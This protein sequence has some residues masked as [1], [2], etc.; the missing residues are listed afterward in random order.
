[1]NINATCQMTE[2]EYERERAELDTIYGR[3]GTEAA[4]KRDQASAKLFY[5]TG[6]AAEQQ[7]AEIVERV[8]AS[9]QSGGLKQVNAQYKRYR[10]GQAA[11][12]EKAMPYGKFIE[13]YITTIVRQVAT[14][15]R[16]I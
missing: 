2:A 3:S 8:K 5:R 7:V 6:R 11:K 12:C 16:M 15:G 1:M 13:P 14:T 4:A 9:N 10:Q